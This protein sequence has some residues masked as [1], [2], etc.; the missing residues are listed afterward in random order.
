METLNK[1]EGLITQIIGPVIDVEFQQGELPEIYNALKIYADNGTEIIAE[2]QQMLGSNRVRT[3][4]MS[5]TDGLKRGMKVI[6]T[7]EPIKVPVG[8]AILGRI[9][10]VI[11]QP[12]DQLGAIETD[13][14]LPI[15]RESPKLVDQNTEVKF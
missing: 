4:A 12:V 10:N 5:S 3:V 8:K 9:L 11:G 15:H 6:N 13:T 7:G 1:N 2:V 14:Y